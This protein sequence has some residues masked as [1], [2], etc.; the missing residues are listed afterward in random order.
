MNEKE[1]IDAVSAVL[2][3]VEIFRKVPDAVLLELAGKVLVINPGAD[4]NIIMQGDKGSSMYII[5]KGEV[6]VHD[7]EFTIAKLGE[8]NFFGEFSLLDEEPRSLSVSTIIPSTLGNI[9]QVDFFVILNKYPE[10][11]RDII[12]V[13][14]KRLRN[15]NQQII[16]QLREKQKELEELVRIRTLDLRQKNEDLENTLNELKKTQEQLVQQA[17]LASLGQITAGIA[18]EIQ[19]PLNFINNFS[20]LSRDLA[21]EVQAAVSSEE[22]LEILSDL[23]INLSKIEEHGKRADRIVKGMLMHS[24][25]SKGEKQ[26]T[27]INY[28]CDQALNL[29]FNSI[30]TNFPQ[31]KCDIRKNIQ[32]NLPQLNVIPQDLSRVIINI[33]N[34]AFYAVNMRCL[35]DKNGYAPVVNVEVNS[36][37]EHLHISVRDNGTGIPAGDHDKIFQPFFTTKPTGQGTG[38]GLSSGYEIVKAHGGTITWKSSENDFT[39]F[40][41]NLPL[42]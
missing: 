18:H 28:L 39:E 33:F 34:N 12:R 36:D 11:T 9:Q 27:D 22:R 8:G 19:N 21:E 20:S 16:N 31:L 6:K 38:L 40:T 3:Q 15:Q 41:V 17:K 24:K 29:A 5:L 1:T 7:K 26:L 23:R 30:S 14:L 32:E 4:E 25:S 37:K 42:K 2:K 35:K 13:M 10:I